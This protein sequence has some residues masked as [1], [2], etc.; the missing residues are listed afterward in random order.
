MSGAAGS[1]FWDAETVRSAAGGSWLALPVAG[2]I[3]G[4]AAIDSRAVGPGQIFFALRGE[5]TDGHRYLAEAGRAGAAVAVVDDPTAAG[6][7]PKGLGVLRVADARVALG[8]LAGAYRRALGSTRFI[9]VTGSNGKTTTTRMIHACLASRLRG[10]CSP[11]SYNNDLGVPLTVLGV[12]PGEHYAVCEVG[13]N[14]PGEIEPLSAIIQPDVAVITSI[15]RA[16]IE[17]FGSVEAITAEKVTVASHLAPGGVVVL[18]ADA[19]SLR[20]WR[21][22]LERVIMFGRADDADFRVGSIQAHAEG[23]SF[24]VNERTVFRVPVLGVHNALNAAAAVAVARRLGVEDEAIRDALAS[25]EAA[26]MRL[27]RLRV[28]EIEVINDAYNANPDSMLAALRTLAGVSSEGSRRVAVIGDMLELGSDGPAAHR[29]IGHAIAGERLADLA[30]L[31]GPL[32]ALA[33]DVLLDAGIE[34]VAVGDL[35]GGGAGRAAA[36]LRRGDTV[37]LKGSRGMRLERVLEALRSS[38]TTTT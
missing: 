19:P 25:F 33:G 6:V 17:S 21:E 13:M 38:T 34:V 1:G 5:R 31:V 4:G 14:A 23:I 26:E 20:P 18:N 30:V 37:L 10:R 2:A 36:L 28:G 16:H 11:K 15:G 22:R 27:S 32:A 35:G 29:E 8:R 24:T 3:K 9:A 12:H 7:F